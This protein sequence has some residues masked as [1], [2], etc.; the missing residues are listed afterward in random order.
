MNPEQK[1]SPKYWV[2]HNKAKEDVY[3]ATCRKCWYDVYDATVE[4]FGE[5]WQDDEGLE[6][7][8]IELKEVD[9]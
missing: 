9:L 7:T 3:M 5:D 1:Y 8:L 6:I 4:I 2:L